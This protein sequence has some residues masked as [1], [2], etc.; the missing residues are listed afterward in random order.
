MGTRDEILAAARRIM[1]ERGY[2]RATTKEIARAAGYSEAALYKH[3]TDKTEIFLGVLS[4]QLP[5]FSTVLGELEA[6]KGTVRANL[7]KIA[8]AALDHYLESFPISASLFSTRELLTAHR[9]AMRERDSGPRNPHRALSRYLR[10]EQRL[11]RLPRAA[12]P[13]AMATLLLG[14]CF[15]QAFL[16]SF[17]GE[18]APPLDTLAKSLVKPLL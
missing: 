2:A 8:R 15:Q 5:A 1:R 18:P 7:A 13:D 4:E 11:G 14:A 9:D 16:L 6:G 3:F 17:E 12:D 10:A